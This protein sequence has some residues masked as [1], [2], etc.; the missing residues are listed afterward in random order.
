MR[1]GTCMRHWGLQQECFVFFYG[2]RFAE[3]RLPGIGADMFEIKGP[4]ITS[5]PEL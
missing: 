4:L 5:N 3:C 1:T 2:L